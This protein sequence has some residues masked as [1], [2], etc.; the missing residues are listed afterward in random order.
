MVGFKGDLIHSFNKNESSVHD[1]DYFDNLEKHNNILLLGDSI[2]DLRMADG[3]KFDNILKIGFLNDKVNFGNFMTFLSMYLYNTSF[4]YVAFH[5]VRTHAIW[6]PSPPPFLHVIGNGNVKET[7]PLGAY[8]LNGKPLYI[9][10]FY[11][12]SLPFQYKS[13]YIFH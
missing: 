4:L 9:S 1:S 8:I 12:T 7:R 6:T 5:L 13:F 3:A 10:S 11:Y 2:G